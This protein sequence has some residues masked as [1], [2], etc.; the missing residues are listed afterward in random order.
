MTCFLQIKNLVFMNLPPS[1]NQPSPGGVRGSLL[2]GLKTEWALLCKM[3]IFQV[4][5]QDPTG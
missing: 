3:N 4:G 2:C 5:T 1:P